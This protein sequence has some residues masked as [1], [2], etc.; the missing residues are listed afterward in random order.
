ME[1]YTAFGIK[2]QYLM[3]VLCDRREK[4]D[5]PKGDAISLIRKKKANPCFMFLLW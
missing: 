5:V 1:Y 3:P 2:K 4:F